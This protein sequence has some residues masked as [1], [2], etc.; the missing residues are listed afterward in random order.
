M[1]TATLKPGRK[2]KHQGRDFTW[3]AYVPKKRKT[4][5]TLLL[6]MSG[7]SNLS[8]ASLILGGK[9]EWG[10]DALQRVCPLPR[11]T[12]ETAADPSTPPQARAPSP[13]PAPGW[14]WAHRGFRSEHLLRWGGSQQAAD[15]LPPLPFSFM[16]QELTTTATTCWV[17]KSLPQPQRSHTWEP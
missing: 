7:H 6:F 12:E 4:T 14:V 13:V 3:S 15:T 1:I 16:G 2:T 8:C 9:V 11:L 10:P 17:S 5:P